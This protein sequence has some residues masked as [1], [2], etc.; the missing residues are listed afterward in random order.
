MLQFLLI[1]KS[2]VFLSITAIVFTTVIFLALIATTSHSIILSDDGLFTRQSLGSVYKLFD[3]GAVDVN[4]D[5]FLD[6]YTVN[7]SYKPVLF[8]NNTKGKFSDQLLN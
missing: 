7:H 4:S 5:G 2:S 6:L 8:V 3:L 1:K